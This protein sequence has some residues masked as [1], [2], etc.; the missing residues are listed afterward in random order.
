MVKKTM[1]SV[2]LAEDDPAS[3]DQLERVIARFS[4]PWQIHSV[5][6]GGGALALLK[7]RSLPHPLTLAVIDIGL[8]DMLGIDVIA[9]V[10]KKLPRLPILVSS[11]F[12]TEDTF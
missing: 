6:T 11:N 10:H 8:P 12:Q 1:N 4:E 5:Q 2:L 3:I 9:Q 7:P